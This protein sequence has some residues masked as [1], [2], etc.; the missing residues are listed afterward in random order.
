[1]F[2]EITS[3]YCENLAKYKMCQNTL[4]VN[5]RHYL[6][7]VPAGFEEVNPSSTEVFVEHNRINNASAFSTIFILLIYTKFSVCVC[8]CI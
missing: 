6:Y 7:K 3:I 4:F 8:E 5:V 2:G 1:M